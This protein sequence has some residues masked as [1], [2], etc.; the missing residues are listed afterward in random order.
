MLRARALSLVL[1]LLVSS[2]MSHNVQSYGTV[3]LSEKTVTVPPG[4]HGP[5]VSSNNGFPLGVGALSSIAA[6]M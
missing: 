1:A 3:D 4:S 6:P 2:C 5:R